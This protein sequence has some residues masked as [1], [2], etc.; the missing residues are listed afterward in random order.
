VGVEPHPPHET[1][2]TVIGGLSEHADPA[3]GAGHSNEDV[4]MNPVSR[5]LMA[6]AGVILVAVYYLPLWSIRVVAPQYND[7]LGMWIHINDVVGHKPHDIQ[8]LNIVNHYIGMKPIDPA[9]VE[10]LTI[11]PWILGFLAAAAVAVALVGRRWAVWTWLGSFAV[12]GTAGL[13]EFYRWMYDYGHNLDP[14]APIKIPGMT[15]QPPLI[16]REQLLNMTATSWPAWGTLIIAVSFTLGLAA[17]WVDRRNRP[18]EVKARA[19]QPPRGRKGPLA[20]GTAAL[21][22]LAIVACNDVE[23]RGAAVDAGNDGPIAKEIAGSTDAHCGGEIT[24]E[25]FGGEL[26]LRSGET[27]RFRSNECLAAFVVERGLDNG[28]I[29]Q[30]RVVEYTHGGRL[31]DAKEARFI[32]SEQRPSPDGLNILATDR[33]LMSYNLRRFFGGVEL[34]WDEM[35]EVVRSE[36]PE[37][38]PGKV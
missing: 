27:H 37:G 2:R 8:N 13:A 7:G 15:Y 19:A 28:Q 38:K 24:G 18:S 5:I 1:G 4:S 23:A 32:R 34:T 17:L 10:V 3:L 20:A 22:A 31:I 25:R 35:L 30:V 29:R 16:G 33:E 21:L 26:V 11:M 12:L 14:M 6:V 9:T 36:W